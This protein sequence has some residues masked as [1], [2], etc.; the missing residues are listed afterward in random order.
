MVFVFPIELAA[1]RAGAH[2][3]VV[4]PAQQVGPAQARPGR[5]RIRSTDRSR[6][7]GAA[8]DVAIQT[9]KGIARGPWAAGA[10]RDR[11][12]WYQPLEAMADIRPAVHWVLSHPGLFL[13]SAGDVG[14]LPLVLAAAAEDIARPDDAAMAALAERTGLASIFGL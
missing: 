5:G 11:G 8:R 7:V 12:T 9:I 13:C 1:I 10:E 14:L 6:R 2:V 4:D 3:D